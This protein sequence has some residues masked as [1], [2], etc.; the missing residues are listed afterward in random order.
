[1]KLRHLLQDGRLPGWNSAVESM[2][3]PLASKLDSGI[4][5]YPPGV[6]QPSNLY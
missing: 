6:H 2:V 4:P 5:G 3:D 1:M